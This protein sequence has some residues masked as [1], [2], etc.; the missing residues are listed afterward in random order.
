MSSK[1]GVPTS[2]VLV[3]M[4][5]R[6][7]RETTMDL[8]RHGEPVGGERYRGNGIDDPLSELGW[9]QMWRC[10]DND[11]PWSRVM[12]SPMKR[13][14]AFAEA[15][16][17]QRGL[18]VHV[19]VDLREI[20][21]GEWEG[22]SKQSLMDQD[23]ASVQ[24]FWADPIH[25]RPK[26]AEPLPVFF[27]RIRGVV[28]RIAQAYSGE[29]LLLVAHAGV[30]RAAT[31]FALRGSL[32]AWSCIRVEYAGVSRITHSHERGFQMVLQRTPSRVGASVAKVPSD[33]KDR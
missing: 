22:K 14:R 8:L 24:R 11:T 32:T 3:S 16:A 21:M 12:S 18:P 26:G 6:E 4:A 5:D 13:C 2:S 25:A 15:L 17:A 20:G 10:I 28:E 1:V 9:G 19:E 33:S 7:V 29:H 31:I 23:P 30:I 27:G